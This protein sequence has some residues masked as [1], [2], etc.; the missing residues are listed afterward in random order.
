M[1]LGVRSRIGRD[2]QPPAAAAARE[3]SPRV[4][5]A[6]QPIVDGDLRLHGY[7]VLFRGARGVVAQPEQWTA[8]LI[9]DGLGELGLRPLV[10]EAL[11]YINVSRGFL[12]NVDPLPFQP[13]GVVLELTED[14]HHTDE[15]LLSRLD[16]LRQQ[17]YR[18]A[19]DDFAYDPSLQ[20]LIER[21]DLVKLDVMADGLERTAEVARILQAHGLGLLAEKVETRE[22]YEFCRDLGFDLFQ[23]YFFA[24]PRE[25]SGVGLPADK[26]AGLAT[27]SAINDPNLTFDDLERVISTDVGLAY[28]LVRYINS[29]F[30]SLSRRIE[31]VHDA[32]VLL[33]QARV[34][35]WATVVVLAG[36]TSSPPPLI[37]L[38]LLRARLCQRLALERGGISDETA[39]MAGLFSVLDALLDVPMEEAV[40]RLP[41]SE[42]LEGGLLSREGRVGEVLREVIAIEEGSL[43]VLA[44]VDAD[45][46]LEASAWA[47]Q[48]LFGGD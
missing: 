27:L 29:G 37:S 8:S 11:A 28:K 36:A 23:G 9:I 35:Q 43:D 12:L 10:G 16:A 48:V 26:L 20:P 32:L 7:E 13:Q 38:A 14:S 47:D 3:T 45:I 40:E 19:L 42:E 24:R 6:R 31:S 39:F 44:G 1:H 2:L 30:F 4:L 18:I 17:G 5:V 22:E 25:V 34:R 15:I 21:A 41:L 46:Y 33:G